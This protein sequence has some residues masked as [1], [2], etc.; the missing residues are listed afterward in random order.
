MRRRRRRQRRRRCCW[1]GRDF[2]KR[3]EME[4]HVA[5]RS[6]HPPTSLPLNQISDRVPEARVTSAC[7]A[8]TFFSD[9][10]VEALVV[11]S[12]R[13]PPRSCMNWAELLMLMVLVPDHGDS[14]VGAFLEDFLCTGV[15]AD[16]AIDGFEVTT[17]EEETVGPV[18]RVLASCGVGEPIGAVGGSGG[19]GREEG[20]EV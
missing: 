10:P 8:A 5:A 17:A 18:W 1:K 11:M 7:A 12:S 9:P 20:V 16:P 2:I 3:V 6:E 14:L 4:P 19:E 13:A 15:H